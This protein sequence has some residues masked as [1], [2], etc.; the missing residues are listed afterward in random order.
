MFPYYIKGKNCRRSNQTFHAILVFR[1]KYNKSL[2]NLQSKA[3]NCNSRN[4]LMFKQW[5]LFNSCCYQLCG[6][7]L[8]V[9]SSVV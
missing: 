6:F 8:Y 1:S 7:G 5:F 4:F 9:T 3:V 2:Y